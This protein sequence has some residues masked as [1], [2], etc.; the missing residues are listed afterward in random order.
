MR[1]GLHDFKQEIEKNN[2][3]KHTKKTKRLYHVRVY[4]LKT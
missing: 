4:S 3:G 2:M 1:T